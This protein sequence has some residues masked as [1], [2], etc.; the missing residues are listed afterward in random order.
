M[1][2]ES[3]CAHPFKTIFLDT[4]GKV[5][6]CCTAR[7]SIGN[8][9]K[10]SIE[11]ILE[12]DRIKEIRRGIITGDWDK[13]NCSQCIDIE[14]IGGH[15]ERAGTIHQYEEM[16]DFTEDDFELQN[17]DLRW[18]NTCNLACN[19]CYENQSSKWASALNKRIPQLKDTQ[20]L[21]NYV[22]KN[23]QTMRQVGLLGGEPLLLKENVQLVEMFDDVPTAYINLLS[24]FAVPFQNNPLVKKLLKMDRVNWAISFENVGNRFEYVRHGASWKMF[25]ENVDFC[26]NRGI[27]LTTNSTYNIYSA[28]NLKEFYEYT[29]PFINHMYWSP[30]L[31]PSHLSVYNLPLELR[32]KAYDHVSEV[33]DIY[34]SNPN[35]IHGLEGLRD[36]LLL[37]NDNDTINRPN[38]VLKWTENLE[39]MFKKE[40]TFRELWPN[41]F[42]I[43][44]LVGK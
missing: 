23:K 13:K 9:H 5:K 14:S 3:F 36:N 12:G 44:V 15:T 24:N 16:K 2:K 40:H 10:Q 25:T 30:I 29:T 18:N 41:L 6:T 32:K 1:K 27:S 39:K 43:L 33:L 17:I 21:L 8:L 19:Y 4:D 42:D 22:R 7:D 37:E 26:L 11:E 20:N 35:H 31:S 28:F 38:D 34:G